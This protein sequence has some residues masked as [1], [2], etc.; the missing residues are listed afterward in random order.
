MSEHWTEKIQSQSGEGCNVAG[1]IKVN[2]VVGNLLFSPGKSFQSNGMNMQEMVPY[3]KDGEVHN[4][5]HVVESFRFESDEEAY[6]ITQKVEMMN[7][8]GWTRMP[9]DHHY[10]HVSGRPP[11]N[12][13]F[14]ANGFAFL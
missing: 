8:L 7:K 5:G 2:K 13:I 11:E 14:N 4:W 12:Y 1:R 9:L 3:L 6:K 10:A